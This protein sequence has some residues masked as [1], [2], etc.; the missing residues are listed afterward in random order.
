MQCLALDEAQV[1]AIAQTAGC[2]EDGKAF[3]KEFQNRLFKVGQLDRPRVII[4]T[5]CR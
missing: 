5:P 2:M 1:C 3:G 4:A